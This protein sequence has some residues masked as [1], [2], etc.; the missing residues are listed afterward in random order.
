M[1]LKDYAC[2]TVRVELKATGDIYVINED[3]FNDELHELLEDEPEPVSVAPAVDS[4]LT[5]EVQGALDELSDLELE[6]LTNPSE[7][8][9]Q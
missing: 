3:E 2:P 1:I 5:P 8:L 6:A 9:S 7:D 4:L